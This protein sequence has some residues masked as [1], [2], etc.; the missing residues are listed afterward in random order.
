MLST[1]Q[2]S[3]PLIAGLSVITTTSLLYYIYTKT[4]KNFVKVCNVKQLFIYP[5][6]AVK[7]VEVPHLEITKYGVKYGVFKDRSWVILDG[8]NR[9]I[10]IKHE[11]RLALTRS[12]IIGDELWID[13]PDMPTLKLKYIENI[14][15][16]SVVSL[17][18]YGQEINGLDCGPEVNHWFQ[19]YLNNDSIRLVQHHS[20]FDYR[21]TNSDK[22]RPDDREFPIIY[23]NKS[24]LHLVNERSVADLNSRFT[25]GADHVTHENF[26]PN[27]L[28]DYPEPWTE[29]TWKWMS[30]N[31][32]N[33]KRLLSCDRCPST[34]VNTDTGVKNM[35]TLTALKSFRPPKGIT[36]S[37]GLGP[38]FGVIFGH[39]SHGVINVDD[40]ISVIFGPNDVD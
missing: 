1:Q 8:N 31:G 9:W 3:V 12:Q 21:D 7:G 11:P 32:V 25:E 22:R 36:K 15:N 23:Q 34:T 39:L 14:D 10:G 33:F 16:H 40:S 5:I 24:G 38:S 6:K 37:K 18:M 35:E 27:L 30:I 19:T 26:R 28:V 13:G 2:L 17:R 20:D 4:R 29:D